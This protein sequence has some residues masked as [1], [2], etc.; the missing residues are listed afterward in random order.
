MGTRTRCPVCRGF[1]SSKLGGYCKNCHSDGE[2]KAPTK[3][4]EDDFYENVEESGEF[5]P[6][7]FGIMSDKFGAER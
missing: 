1:G 4:I 5:F 7:D 2:E 6:E 3:H